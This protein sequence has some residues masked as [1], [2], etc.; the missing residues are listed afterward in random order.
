VFAQELEVTQKE[1]RLTKKEVHLGQMEEV[2][3]ELQ[4]K[5]NAYNKMLKKQWDQQEAAVENLRKVQ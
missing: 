1:K 3:S 2:I 5:L 4:A